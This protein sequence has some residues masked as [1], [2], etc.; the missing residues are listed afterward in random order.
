MVTSSAV[1]RHAFYHPGAVVPLHAHDKATIVYGVGGPCIERTP[2]GVVTSKGRLTIHPA[3][4]EHSLEYQGATHVLAI[5]LEGEAYRLPA[6]MGTTRLPATAYDAFWRMMVAVAEARPAAGIEAAIGDIVAEAV[7]YSSRQLPEPVR[8][9]VEMLHSDW[10]A[11][12][13]ATRISRKARI[14]A[15]YLCRLFKMHMG[16]TLREYGQCL[17]IDYARALLWGTGLTLA[18]VAAE[19]AFADQSHLTR[20]LRRHSAKTP[21]RLRRLAPFAGRHLPTPS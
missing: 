6:K 19:T 10:R 11:P 20:V 17:R 13:S 14:S 7:A 15:P 9:A 5:E 12:P 1:I 2:S 21:R 18:E 4:Y 8:I 16:V 3:G